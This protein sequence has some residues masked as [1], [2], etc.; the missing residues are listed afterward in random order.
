MSFTL[1]ILN[2]E[3][4]EKLAAELNKEFAN[5]IKRI[6]STGAKSVEGVVTNADGSIRGMVDGRD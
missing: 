2:K 4:G 1:K 6:E 3:D 5:R